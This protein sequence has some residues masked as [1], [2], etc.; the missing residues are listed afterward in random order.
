MADNFT[1]KDAAGAIKTF[2]AEDIGAGVL[3][4]RVRVA[5]IAAGGGKRWTT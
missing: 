3:R 5:A 1:A 4:K 2:D